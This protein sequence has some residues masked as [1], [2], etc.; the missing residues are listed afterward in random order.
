MS[1]SIRFVYQNKP[2]KSPKRKIQT[3]CHEYSE[4]SKLPTRQHQFMS[5]LLYNIKGSHNWKCSV[6]LGELLENTTNILA[7]DWEKSH[8]GM[9]LFCQRADPEQS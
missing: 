8:Q 5:H 3:N 7:L 4:Y 1:P 9:F 2:S 6:F